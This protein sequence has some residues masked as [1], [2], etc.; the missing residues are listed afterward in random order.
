MRRL[1]YIFLIIAVAT[2][3]FAGEDGVSAARM[4]KNNPSHLTA[5]VISPI[6]KEE[7]EFYEITGNSEKDLLCQITEKGCTWKDGRKY[8]SVTSWNITWNYGYTRASQGCRADS[9][10]ATV[11]IS[12]RYPK[13]ARADDAP[14]PLVGSWETYLEKLIIHENGHRDIAV[15]AA[16]GLTRAVAELPAAPSCADVDRELQALCRERIT[17]LNMAE[18]E[19]D[20]A[21]NHGTMQGAIFPRPIYTVQ[22]IR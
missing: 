12:F 15:K 21:T 16:A 3:S 10:I 8:T 9:F 1:I 4:D 7:Y 2:S 19:Y 6:V 13:W 11:E 17:E 20:E 14:Q 18:M 22:E 5:R